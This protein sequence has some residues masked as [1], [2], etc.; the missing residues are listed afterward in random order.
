MTISFIGSEAENGAGTT[1]TVDLSVPMDGKKYQLM[2]SKGYISGSGV[3]DGCIS[4]SIVKG[5]VAHSYMSDDAVFA[6][7][8]ESTVSLSG[9]PLEAGDIIRIYWQNATASLGNKL[10]GKAWLKVVD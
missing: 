10:V 3:V 8:R 2:L 4:H 9:I 5:S 7:K 1:A 6:G